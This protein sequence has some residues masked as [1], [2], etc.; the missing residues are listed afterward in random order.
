MIKGRLEGFVL[1]EHS[2][3]GGKLSM[4]FFEGLCKP[5]L[6]LADVCSAGIIRAVCKP[7]GNISRVKPLC[8]FNA[9]FRV[10]QGTSTDGLIRIPERTILVFLILKKIG[11]DGS[12]RNSITGGQAPDFICALYAFRTIPQ[13]VQSYRWTDS[14]EELHLTC[15]AELLFGSGGR[16]RLNEFPETSSRICETPGRKFDA[17]G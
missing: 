6:A 15:I 17:K 9:V 5:L 10:P 12:R 11:I 14:R 2:L 8:D 16:R 4:R 3:V 1:D 13:H 7:Q